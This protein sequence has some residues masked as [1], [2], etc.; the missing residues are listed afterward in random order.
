VHFFRRGP[1]LSHVSLCALASLV[2]LIPL[3]S[4]AL[5]GWSQP[6][7]Y[8]SDLALGG[9]LLV[10]LW[11][12][13]LWLS[14]PVLLFWGLLTLGNAEL[15]KAV[16]RM[17]E[18]TDLQ[19]LA[20]PQFID[21]SAGG[22]SHPT[23]A[24]ALLGTGLLF[25]FSRALS[26]SPPR[27]LPWRWFAVPALLFVTHGLYQFYLPS[28]ADQWHQYNLPHK[29]LA[30]GSNLAHARL[31]DWL[32]RDQ[33]EVPVDV[34]GLNRLDLNGTP[35]LA[36]AGQARNV[37]IITL[38]GVPGAYLAPSQHALGSHYQEQLMPRL[39]QWAARGMLTPDY[40]LHSHQTIRGLYSMLCGDYSKLDSGTPK[41]IELLNDSQRNQQCLPH[42]LRERGFSTHYLQGAGLRFMAK[43][44]IMPHM[45]FEKT[46][47]RD[48]FRNK[49]YLEFPWGMDDKAFFE[50]SLG[51]V[52]QLQRQKKPWM[53]TLLTVG[54]HQPYSA[55]DAY[56]LRYPT[57]KQAAIAYLD[58]AVSDFLDALEIQGV[59]KNTLVM[60]TSDESHGLEDVRLASAWG[61]NLVLAPE[62]AQL[63]AIKPGTY[64]HVDLSASVLDY[65]ALPVPDVLSGRSM[66]R[67]YASGREMISYTNGLLRLHDGKGVLTE[68]DFQQSCRRYA[69]PGFIA[70]SARYLGRFS[71]REGRQLAERAALL[72]R[73]LQSGQ[74]GQPYQFAS[75]ER[76]QLKRQATGNDWTDNLIGAQYLELPKGTRTRVTLRIRGS[77]LD[78][79]GA[80]LLLKAKE[81]ERNVALNIPPIPL[82]KSGQSVQLSFDFDN[83][84]TRKAFSFHLLGEG[85]GSIQIT[86]FSVV[87]EPLL[88]DMLAREMLPAPP[89]APPTAPA[90]APEQG[91]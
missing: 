32:H 35:L 71:G 80:Q 41:G 62:Q 7:G 46:L 87:S 28:E 39:S 65:F 25:F 15:V 49:A 72:D 89:P 82:I 57:A 16:G 4:R 85:R 74:T 23:L 31:D 91:L 11:R 29:L 60:L 33:P 14:T 24:L 75:N 55:P 20:D 13:S 73:S 51:Y 6:L 12:R 70:D 2:V 22:L 8:L 37:L 40:V 88:D 36:K 61:F 64:G 83:P 17:P 84:Q 30:E 34:A 21:N 38:E 58:D 66:F 27:H 81:Y 53:L 1:W 42:Q 43:D 59:L 90:P 45:G 50:G 54:T 69:S 44:K 78:R 76:I 68:C 10:L 79:Q 3:A 47:G 63:P 56:L 52:K 5:L 77:K 48:W 18:A 9:L 19:F 86:D 26:I 67:D